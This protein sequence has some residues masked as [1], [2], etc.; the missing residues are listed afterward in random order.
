MGGT[1]DP[2]KI[3]RDIATKKPP[4]VSIVPSIDIFHTVEPPSP[5]LSIFMTVL[6][7]TSMLGVNIMASTPAVPGGGSGITG[8]GGGSGTATPSIGVL[9]GTAIGSAGINSA[10]F[11]IDGLFDDAHTV[12]TANANGEWVGIDFGSAKSVHQAWLYPRTG[13]LSRMVGG[14]K[15][16][17]SNSSTFAS[18][19]SE[20]TINDITAIQGQFLPIQFPVNGTITPTRYIRFLPAANQFCDITEMVVY[21]I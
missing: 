19:V 9:G 11:L 17:T 4:V 14:S 8:N 12:S 5:F 2:K 6:P 1:N 7:L 15:V 13:V 3:W 16:Q 20:V 18:I 21:G 10:A